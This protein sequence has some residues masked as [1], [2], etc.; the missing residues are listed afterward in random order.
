MPGL[1]NLFSCVASN[2]VW[3]M[4]LE[5]QSPFVKS[6]ASAGSHKHQPLPLITT[7]MAARM[8]G[9]IQATA[10]VQILNESQIVSVVE[11]MSAGP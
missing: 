7:K 6:S 2:R 1:L 11:P 10:T 4:Q 5:L 3:T 9:R 8:L